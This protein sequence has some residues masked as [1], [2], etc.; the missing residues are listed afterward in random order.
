[1]SRDGEA[2]S[3]AGEKTTQSP[4]LDSQFLLLVLIL[5]LHVS[6]FPLFFFSDFEDF[7]R[8]DSL[9]CSSFIQGLTT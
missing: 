2:G 5:T 9:V 3:K 7:S 1:M 6:F 8:I 4:V